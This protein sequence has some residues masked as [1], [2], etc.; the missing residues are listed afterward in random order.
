MRT[1]LHE[2][3]A[4]EIGELV[5]R[6]TVSPVEVVQ[7]FLDRIEKHNNAINAFTYVMPDDALAEAKAL[8]SC[9]MAGDYAGPFAGVPVG[10]KDFLPSKKGWTNSHGG[11]PHLVRE[12]TEDSEFYKAVRAMGAIAIGKTN[13][14][15]FGFSGACQNVMYGATR[16]PFDLTRTS[17]G[18]SGGTAAAVAAGLIPLGEGGDAGGSIRIPAGWCN[19]FGFKPSA[20]RIPSVCRPDGWAATHPFCCNGAITRTVED[21]IRVFDNMR[22][23][24]PRDP[25]STPVKTY[26]S[27]EFIILRGLTVGLT[28]DFD[29]YP[30][31]DP[32]VRRV[33]ENLAQTLSEHGITVVP[34]RFPN[35]KH[36]LKQMMECWAWSI[37]IDT[38]LDLEQWK[39]EGLDL[40]RDHSDELPPEFIKYNEIA[41]KAGIQDMRMFNE[42]RTDIL[43]NF[44]DAFEKV[45]VILSP[46][47]ICPPIPTADNGH[48]IEC[49]GFKLDPDT[50]FIAFGET[51]LVNFIGYPAAS[52]PA[53]L[54]SSGLPVGAQ[55][56]APKYHEGSIIALS[57]LIEE[58]IP[59][60]HHYALSMPE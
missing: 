40:V 49:D 38:A 4:L 30:S 50:N 43:D 53:G 8:E 25:M 5:N 12:D 60:T 16:N 35:W 23:Y 21:S 41:A 6:K 37:S 36:G 20:G 58:K 42:I 57:E 56:I 48:C 31:I 27:R 17:G 26:P 11:V 59:W 7:T 15:A 34:I 51:P 45:D 22:G 19:L 14:P 33:I 32:E 44:V 10:L 13:A 29:L 18:S 3:S 9:I 39:Q 54:T 46:T 55:F 2:L 24:N 47:A 52:V 1:K 28:L